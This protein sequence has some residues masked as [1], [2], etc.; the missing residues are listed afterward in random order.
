MDIRNTGRMVLR[1]TPEEGDPQEY[2]IQGFSISYSLNQI[3][4]AVCQLNTGIGLR[5]EEKANLHKP[6]G[7]TALDDMNKAEILADI[8][9]PYISGIKKTWD[10]VGRVPLFEGRIS[11]TSPLLTRQILTTEVNLVHWLGDLAFS[12]AL[13]EQAGHGSHSSLRMQAIFQAPGAQANSAKPSFIHDYGLSAYLTNEKIQEDLWGSALHP[14]FLALTENDPLSVESADTRCVIQPSKDGNAILKAA[15][16]RFDGDQAGGRNPRSAD[17]APLKINATV[18]AVAESVSLF[19]SRTLNDSLGGRSFWDKILEVCAQMGCGVVPLVDHAMVVPIAIGLR[20]TFRRKLRLNDLTMMR[21]ERW[22]IRPIRSSLIVS[23]RIN[24]EA[25]FAASVDDGQ[26][27]LTL[28]RG[29]LVGGCYVPE[30]GP[31]RGLVLVGEA[32]VWLDQVPAL[33]NS[34]GRTI[35]AGGGAPAGSTTNKTGKNPERRGDKDGKTPAGVMED[36]ST[37]Y[38]NFAHYQYVTEVLKNRSLILSCPTL[39][40]DIAPG[41]S[42]EIEGPFEEPLFGARLFGTVVRVTLSAQ[43][44]NGRLH[45]GTQLRIS[46]IRRESENEKD[47]FSVAAHP[48]YSGA[49][50]LGTALS[51]ALEFKD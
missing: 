8:Q 10:D 12:S 15:L 21:P 19:L 24:S 47:G 2:A 28:D 51:D 3:P 39:R 34:P 44:Q 1:V 38:S 33:V 43:V 17:Y 42:V 22:N 9:G 11:G 49:Q 25:G 26:G 35:G 20:S 40:T 18:D 30:N 27:N 16:A 45:V 4:Q 31:A 37:L 32:P 48:L 46:G 5:S 7:A 29:A 23:G 36:I 6:A 50:F 14:A 41:S 13:S